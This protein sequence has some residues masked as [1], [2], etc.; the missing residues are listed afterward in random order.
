MRGQA[1]QFAERLVRENGAGEEKQIR[2]AFEL[3]LCRPASD[4]DVVKASAFLAQQRRQIEQDHSTKKPIAAE[5]STRRALA[6]FCLVL[7]NTNEFAYI[8]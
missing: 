5:E 8:E 2:A 7:L 6:D 3:A 4:S 1:A